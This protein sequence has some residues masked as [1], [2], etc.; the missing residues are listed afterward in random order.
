M[1]AGGRKHC[2]GPPLLS[3]PKFHH[4]LPSEGH[5]LSTKLIL[6]PL[7]FLLVVKLFLF[8]NGNKKTFFNCKSKFSLIITA[9]GESGAGHFW[10]I[11]NPFQITRQTIWAPHI[12]MA[13]RGS[14]SQQSLFCPTQHFPLCPVTSRQWQKERTCATPLAAVSLPR[15]LWLQP[16]LLVGLEESDMG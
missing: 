9:Q 7:Y 5:S 1:R 4:S 14:S 6:F 10:A 3:S 8:Q 16:P 13:P 15:S 12:S 11:A 2:L